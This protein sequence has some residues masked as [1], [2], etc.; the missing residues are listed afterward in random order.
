MGCCGKG[1]G[2][3]Q[4]AFA[5]M[6]MAG[7][8]RPFLGPQTGQFALAPR[9]LVAA[10]PVQIRA[11]PPGGLVAPRADVRPLPPPGF[12]PVRPPP[13]P[14]P[15]SAPPPPREPRPGDYVFAQP[16]GGGT[17]IVMWAFLN[18]PDSTARAGVFAWTRLRVLNRDYE[19]TGTRFSGGR[20]RPPVGY[21]YHV[22]DEAG[23]VGYVPVDEVVF[24]PP[25]TAGVGQLAFMPRLPDVAIAPRAEVRQRPRFEP[26]PPPPSGPN[27]AYVPAGTEMLSL[28]RLGRVPPYV[29]PRSAL[30]ETFE[31][32]FHIPSQSNYLRV[33]TVDRLDGVI[34]MGWIRERD[35]STPPPGGAPLMPPSTGFWGYAG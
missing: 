20:P 10:P 27:T 16:K 34:R 9:A 6:R 7:P 21:Y 15:P 35:L 25:D 17:E 19:A 13:A 18:R 26:I 12:D 8:A 14:L 11:L 24:G 32:S 1:G 4:T 5:R 22:D 2:R 29:F 30:V 31:R 33:R 23:H 3:R 28:D